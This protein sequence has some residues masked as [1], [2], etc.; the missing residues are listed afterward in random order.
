MLVTLLKAYKYKASNNIFSNA[1]RRKLI[2][3]HYTSKFFINVP[4]VEISA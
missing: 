1:T 3:I 4:I 2:T